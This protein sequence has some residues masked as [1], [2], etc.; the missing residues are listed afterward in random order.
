MNLRLISIRLLMPLLLNIFAASESKGQSYGLGFLSHDVITDKRTSLD[1]FPGNGFATDDNFQLSF[2]MSFLQERTDY[3]GYIFRIIE[4]NKKNIDLI[5]N[6]RDF[7][8]DAPLADSNHFK[9]IINDHLTKITFNICEQQLMNQWNKFDLKFDFKSDRLTLTVNNKS[10]TENNAHLNKEGVYKFLWGVNNFLNYKTNDCPPIKIRNVSISSG[11]KIRHFWPMNEISGNV[12][13]DTIGHRNANILN[14]LW[15]RSLHRNW[16]AE[17]NF[18]ITGAASIAF[19]SENEML[20]IVGSDSLWTYSIKN[21]KLTGVPYSSGK[22]NLLPSNESFY[23]SY[24][25]TLYNYY[26]EKKQKQINAFNFTSK[27][28]SINYRFPLVLTDYWQTNNFFSMAD[29][30]LY[31]IGGYGQLTYKNIVNRYHFSDKS[32]KEVITN[33]DYFCPRYLAAAGTVDSGRTAYLLGGYGSYN[34]QQ[35]LNPKNLYDLVRFDVKTHTFKKVYEL[36]TPKEDFAFANSMVIDGKKRT[37]SSLVYSNYHY[38]SNLR[39]LIGSLDHPDY[40]IVGNPIPYEFH[41]THSFSNL[42]FSPRSQK[43]IAVTL[44]RLE[45]TNQTSVKIYSLLFP[46]DITPEKPELATV[47]PVISHSFW[48]LL[49]PLTFI[50]G[51][52]AFFKYKRVESGIASGPLTGHTEIPAPGE[53][54]VQIPVAVP[55]FTVPKNAIYLF[56]DLQ[57]FNAEGDNIITH[58]TSLVKELFLAIIIYSLRSGRG[59]NPEKL[60]ELMWSDKSEDSAKNNRSAN[61]SK[62]KGLLQQVGNINLSKETGNW[63]IDINYAIIYADYY[64]YQQIVAERKTLNKEKIIQL[65]DIMQRGSFLS[66]IEYPWL[67][68]IK[69]EIS[70]EI[71]DISLEYASQVR[72]EDNPELMIKLANCI[73]SFDSVNEE[74]MIIKCKSLAHLGKHSLAKSAFEIF[75]K[76]FKNLYGEEFKKNFHTVLVS[77]VF[78][79]I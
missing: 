64:H 54:T 29:T 79:S 37:F 68:P 48:I 57:F 66:N 63:K 24:S 2:E 12:A 49:F 11:N 45:Q 40:Q 14:P 20:Y 4:N 16:T 65:I 18:R 39:L 28:W 22:L 6:R 7:R 77:T 9:L 42:Y 17:Q 73:F 69:S 47:A 67:D 52:I 1:L 23:N 13:H 58:F 32:W 62:L 56:G 8:I 71:V 33:G 51:L 30:S 43:L 53:Q 3:F 46:P 5:F 61:I 41:D 31:V 27:S 36:K 60:I 55:Q 59:V 38:N 15:I 76:E 44:F 25:H 21:L 35:V 50:I 74:A 26:I 72:I 70:N 10:Y 78:H 34:G 19:N 75:L